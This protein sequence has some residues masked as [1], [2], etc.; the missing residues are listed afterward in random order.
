MIAPKVDSYLFQ[1]LIICFVN[2]QGINYIGVREKDLKFVKEPVVDVLEKDGH[3]VNTIVCGLIIGGCLAI[4]N[5]NLLEV[6]DRD[7]IKGIIGVKIIRRT[8]ILK[9]IPLEDI[10]RVSQ[11]RTVLFSGPVL[12]VETQNQEHYF[13]FNHHEL[14]KGKDDVMNDVSLFAKALTERI[15]KQTK[16]IEGIANQIREL[17]KLKDEGLITEDEFEMKKKQLLGL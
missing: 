16:E 7:I 13:E 4:T 15:P 6:S 17:A 10:N 8:K 3:R 14:H 9:T 11:D 1:R 2:H 5:E 12:K